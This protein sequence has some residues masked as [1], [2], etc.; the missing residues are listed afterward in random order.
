MIIMTI[1]IKAKADKRFEVMQTVQDINR[2]SSNILNSIRYEIY[3]ELE[4]NNSFILVGKWK[5]RESLNQYIASY[6]FSV[7]LGT[8]ALLCEPIDIQIFTVSHSEGMEAVHSLR[9][10]K[11]KQTTLDKDS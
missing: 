2:S 3:C 4:D 1:K 8:K 10:P 9:E 11:S 5:K 7:L 6:K